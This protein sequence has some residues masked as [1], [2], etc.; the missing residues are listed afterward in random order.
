MNLVDE[1]LCVG[2][3]MTVI[4]FFKVFKERPPCPP[5]PAAVAAMTNSDNEKYL[6]SIKR[7]AKNINYILLLISYG[8]Y[9]IRIII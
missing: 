7:L 3:V 2:Y 5:S 6:K 8:E 1:E 4:V 9:G